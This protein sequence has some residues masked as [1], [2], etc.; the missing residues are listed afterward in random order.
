MQG[1]HRAVLRR[2]GAGESIDSICQSNSW[3]RAEFDER[4]KRE[5]AS[6]AP[7][8]DGQVGV[9]VNAAVT[10]E[11]D[12]W[13]IP[14][15]F[16]DNHRDLFFGFGYAMAQDRLFQMDYLRRKGL[17]RLAE[18]LGPEGIP[19]DLTA[20]T[21]G[22]NRIANEEW[23]RLPQETRLLQQAFADGVNAW[24][25]LCGEQIAIEFDL[26]DYR[27][28]LW[29]P[30]DSLA[31]ES[32]F[33]WYL[34]GRFPVIVMPELA[35]RVLGDGPLYRE[36][37][38]GEADEEAVVPPEAYQHL[39]Q[40]LGQRPL[41][42]VGQAT[43]DPEGTGS[44]NWVV[45]GRHCKA[46][47]P[48]V[49]SDPH[50]A[51]EAVSCWYEA[52][53]CGGDFNVAGMAY[54]GMPAIMFGRNERVAWGITNN[55][56]SLRDLYQERVDSEH[57]N[58]FQ[59][60]GAWEPAREVVET[61]R[62]R[63]EEPISRTIRFSRNGPVVDEILPPPGNTTG[64]VTLK[65]LGAFQ[66]GWLT[67]LL[68]M[69]R[70]QTVAEFREALRPWHVPT[71]NLVIAD[72]AGHIAV[73]CAGRIPQRKTG[74]RGYRA[75]WEP[76][77]QWT[78]LLPFES[79]PHAVDPSRGWLAS[80]NNRLAE[81]D[82][83]FPL[84]GTWI[85]GYRA[86]R[87]R[88]MLEA[89]IA[90]SAGQ[91]GSGGFTV[92]D[93]RAMHHDTVSLRA[94]T[95]LPPLIAALTEVTDPQIQ[96]AVKHLKTWDGRIEVEL[97][98][99][100]LFNVFF[101]FWSKA[102]SDVRFEGTTSELLARQ[103]EGIASRLLTDDPH[104]WFP[105]GER[106]AR[107]RRVFSE[108]LAFL[109]EQYGPD[110]STWTWGRVHRM[111]LKHV[112]STRGDLAQLLNDGGGPVKG[113]MIT[114]C[115]TGSGPNWVA[116]TG[117]GYRLIADLSTD[118]LLAVDCQS[119]SGNPGTPHYSDQLAAWTSGEYHSLPLKRAAVAEIA[120]QRLQLCPSN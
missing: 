3:T 85:G 13:G 61:I 50:I 78:G 70:A 27:P 11:R 54:V 77:Q 8:C 68:G 107:L 66:G 73:H 7:R 2:L 14:H 47:M 82:Y 120:V 22:L 88:E 116:N 104:A 24:I 9:G 44:N 80:A 109:A 30:I 112:L 114:V 28:E 87:I 19:L 62:I 5:A 83:P 98:A 59:F 20:R 101:T 89:V 91:S 33:R 102:V 10:I 81:D 15:I 79:M 93:F 94:V 63:G 71:F 69:N 40:R 41:E 90:K 25:K 39:K 55:I 18:V 26:L 43:G 46:G 111:P 21:V 119:Q 52:H 110:M 49:A 106:L 84:F 95:C 53:L 56:C 4:W 37:L 113:D 35:K 31:I 16:A 64:P 99:P 97:V 100:A 23:A 115:N 74:E 17:G 48:M 45:A 75:G 34:T 6:R 105:V 42:S 1:L 96:S 72:V 86:V 103:V 29:S 12:R 58:C 118:C 108:T 65:W 36:F 117:A 57:P 60:D 51:I 67:A 76:D 92:D 38:L 32:E